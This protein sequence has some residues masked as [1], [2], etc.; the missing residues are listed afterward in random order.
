[1]VSPPHAPPFPDDPTTAT[2]HLC[3]GAYLDETFRD[4]A[5]R[6][7]YH[8]PARA[9]ALSYGFSVTPVLAHCRRARRVALIRDAAVTAVLLAALGAAP[10]TPLHAITL[11][12]VLL[13]V[14]S[15][16]W[17]LWRHAQL[18]RFRPG[19]TPTAPGTDPRLRE[20]DLQQYGN[21]VVQA[22]H[23]RFLGAG[24]VIGTWGLTQ[25]LGP[26]PVP[27][28]AA[29]VVA[30]L[31]WHL[32]AL[33]GGPGTVPEETIPGLT[34]TDRVHLA[35]TEVGSLAS[36]TPPD[37]VAEIIRRPTG[38]ARHHLACQVASSG[39]E[40]VTTV[41]IHVAVQAGALYLES[42][43]TALTP[44]PE[45]Y[46]I[47][48]LPDATGRQAWFRAVRSGL[49]GTPRVAVRA[50]FRLLRA[51]GDAL[52]DNRAFTRRTAGPAGGDRV[53]TLRLGL[54]HGA[55]VA[56]R[57][58]ACPPDDHRRYPDIAK[59]QRLIEQHVLDAIRHFLSASVSSA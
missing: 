1:M 50:P 41:H 38:P 21:T 54:D 28:D 18:E 30:H 7:V 20:I 58:L 3:A 55:R 12:A 40:V 8:R 29:E 31:R 27:F 35:G 46:R 14:C 5:M 39:G 34:V 19:R 25:P 44:C 57:E 43:T 13:P 15:V 53:R 11:A 42:T 52:P 9:V 47:V 10:I 4:T 36:I 23:H 48:D 24:P 6:E 17:S 16:A 33:V 37:L 45:A 22:G 49:L 26:G 32:G 59:H 2:R 51:L 56:V